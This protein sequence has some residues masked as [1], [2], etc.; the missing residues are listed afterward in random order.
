MKL[1]FISQQ[2]NMLGDNPERSFLGKFGL[3][4]MP[5]SNFLRWWLKPSRSSLVVQRYKNILSNLSFYRFF[6]VTYPLFVKF[7]SFLCCL[8]RSQTIKAQMR[9]LFIIEADGSFDSL[10]DL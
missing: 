8:T 3:G 7:T 1:P 4:S 10:R 2:R 5:N 9:A 6:S